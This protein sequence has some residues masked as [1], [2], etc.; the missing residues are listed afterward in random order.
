M[1]TNP[2]VQLK[3]NATVELNDLDLAGNI[4]ALIVHGKGPKPIQDY[5]IGLG[6][7]SVLLD[8]P[9]EKEIM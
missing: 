5:L 6:S 9:I 3:Q 2:Q 4:S 7:Q 1:T 8:L